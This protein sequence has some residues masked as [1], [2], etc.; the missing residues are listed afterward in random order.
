MARLTYVALIQ[1]NVTEQLTDVTDLD[2]RSNASGTPILYATSRS[3]ET[4]SVFE[5]DAAGNVSLRDH[6]SLN[7]DIEE[8]EFMTLGGIDYIVT[9]GPQGG[10]P[11]LYQLNTEGQITGGATSLSATPIGMSAMAV[12][13]T[14]GGTYLY[15]VGADESQTLGAFQVTPGI[16]LDPVTLPTLTDGVSRLLQAQIGN[17]GYLFAVTENGSQIFSYGV[18]NDGT[19]IARG[20]SGTAQGLGLAGV[21]DL[22]QVRVA[23]NGSLTPVDYIIDDLGTRFQNATALETVTVGMRVFVLAGGADDGISLF[24]LRP[25]GQLL[26]HDTITDDFGITLENVSGVAATEVNGVLRVFV[27]SATETGINPAFRGSR[28]HW[29][30]ALRHERE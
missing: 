21:S 20:E 24:E 9:L 3:G 15:Y 12:V 13:E 26:H 8:I 7:M 19:L 16:T 2:I 22:K 5:I 14:G 30:D 29:N 1:R 18:Q 25:A 4:I 27:G 17:T 23:G 10:T 28:P 11:Q 6:Q